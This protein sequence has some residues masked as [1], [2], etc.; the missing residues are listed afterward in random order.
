MCADKGEKLSWL[1]TEKHTRTKKRKKARDGY[2]KST[3]KVG[4][5]SKRTHREG[6]FVPLRKRKTLGGGG[7]KIKGKS[8]KRRC[9]GP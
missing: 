2:Q 5:R 3:E 4:K 9:K 6:V 7:Q 8:N 1:E